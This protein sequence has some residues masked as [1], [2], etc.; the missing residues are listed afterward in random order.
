MTR[1]TRQLV[2]LLLLAIVLTGSLLLVA[3]RQP[4]RAFNFPAR[5]AKRTA[6]PA[7]PAADDVASKTAR[8]D[9]TAPLA[10]SR[11]PLSR[12]TLHRR[13]LDATRGKPS[14]QRMDAVFQLGQQAGQQDFTNALALA[15]RIPVDWMRDVFVAGIF[16]SRGRELSGRALEE[17]A[18]DNAPDLAGADDAFAT[19][20]AIVGWALT[21]PRAAIAFARENG[22]RMMPPLAYAAWGLRDLNAMLADANALPTGVT[23]FLAWAQAD[24]DR[25]VEYA[26]TLDENYRAV[27]LERIAFGSASDWT[28]TYRPDFISYLNIAVAGDADEFIKHTSLQWWARHDPRAAVEYL[29]SADNADL[30]E[31]FATW[32]ESDTDAALEWLRGYYTQHDGYT[33]AS[34]AF[35]KLVEVN[36]EVAVRLIEAVGDSGAFLSW[37][38]LDPRAAFAWAATH[39]E[40]LGIDARSA[41]LNYA[42][43]DIAEALEWVRALPDDT[44]RTEALGGI[45][46][47]QGYDDDKPSTDWMLE[48][49]AGQARDRVVTDY[50]TGILHH[51]D[52]VTGLGDAARNSPSIDMPGLAN[53][54]QQSKLD[55]AEKRRL[56]ALIYGWSSAR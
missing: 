36:P 16:V 23:D 6:T 43:W 13:I 15:K 18:G 4:R 21:D 45:A 41:G 33:P 42:R 34:Q 52:G 30:S 5:P 46:L 35:S 39:D 22:D 49:P 3:R 32:A 38:K 2:A 55:A 27:V 25:A 7:L 56:L 53:A 31:A 9:D 1:R 50:V 54:V 12:A 28:E 44:Q 24:P 47:A 26:M 29:A 10:S 11:L 37:V 14:R 8:P 51:A 19:G 20:G 48:V 17:L 40:P